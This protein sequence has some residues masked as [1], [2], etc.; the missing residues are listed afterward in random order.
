MNDQNNWMNESKGYVMTL[1]KGI[2]IVGIWIGVGLTSFG[3]GKVVVAV[4]IFAM[5]ATIVVAA[6]N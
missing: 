6:A 4:A 2:A 3:A 5:I 1:G